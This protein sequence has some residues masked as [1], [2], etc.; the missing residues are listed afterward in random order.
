MQEKYLLDSGVLHYANTIMFYNSSVAHWATSF[1]GD[2]PMWPIMQLFCG[3]L[4]L[5][6][7]LRMFVFVR[8]PMWPIM[9]ENA[10]CCAPVWHII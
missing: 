8:I 4:P 3:G 9:Q 7:I 5:W 10:L 2:I 1:W 6:H